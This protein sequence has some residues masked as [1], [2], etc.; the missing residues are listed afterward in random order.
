MQSNGLFLSPVVVGRV[1]LA[2]VVVGLAVVSTRSTRQERTRQKSP[3]E[4][5]KRGRKEREE[6]K[7]G[8]E[9]SL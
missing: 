2:Y 9:I 6:R 5:G 7:E 8:G 1:T 4:E 3:E